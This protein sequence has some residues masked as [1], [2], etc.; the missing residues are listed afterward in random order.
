[1]PHKIYYFDLYGRA[2]AARM[3]YSHAKVEFEDIRLTKEQFAEMKEAGKF[4]FGQLPLL[5]TDDGKSLSQSV[6]INRYVARTNGYYPEDP[7]EQWANDSAVDALG[8]LA[9]NAMKIHFAPNEEAKTAAIENYMGKAMPAFLE[10]F[11]KRAEG[12]K[13]MGGDNMM[14]ADFCTAAFFCSPG[15]AQAA[16]LIAKYPA[17]AAMV[18]AYKAELAD[19]LANRP[20]CAF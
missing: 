15:M 20:K 13:F 9:M 6:A 11:D 10:K 14:F 3:M 8:D 5:E 12:K 1:M 4:E 17:F 18:E 7:V 16:D 19:Y 2:E